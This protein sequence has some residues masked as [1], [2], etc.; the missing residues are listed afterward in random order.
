MRA[1]KLEGRGGGI[2]EGA[3]FAASLIKK[4]CFYIAFVIIFVLMT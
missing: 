1:I 3:F 2:S 4:P